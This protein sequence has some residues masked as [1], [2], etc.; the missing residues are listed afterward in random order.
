MPIP[1]GM[2]KP[3]LEAESGDPLTFEA[4]AFL[5]ALGH[6]KNDRAPCRLAGEYRDLA[7]D[8]PLRLVNVF[9]RQWCRKRRRARRR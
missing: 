6:S 1:K 9:Y 3:V 5:W 8:N 4:K 7:A 2:P